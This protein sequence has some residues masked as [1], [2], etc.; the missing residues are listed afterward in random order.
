MFSVSSWTLSPLLVTSMFTTLEHAILHVL[1]SLIST[2]LGR[3][4]AQDL[5]GTNLWKYSKEGGARG[6]R[7]QLH[8]I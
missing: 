3:M 2:P 8:A 7:G 4:K 1:I 6:E 5:A